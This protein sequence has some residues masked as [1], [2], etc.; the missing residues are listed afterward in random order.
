[1]K[2]NGRYFDTHVHLDL[3]DD[4]GD[5][6]Q[7]LHLAR[8]SGVGQ[9]LVPGVKRNRW[10]DL[11]RLCRSHQGLFAAPGLHPMAADQWNDEARREL[12]SLLCQPKVAAIGEIGL[13]ATLPSPALNQQE[14]AFTGQLR[15]AVEVGLPVLIYCRQAT[16]RLL[17]ILDR[18]HARRVGGIFHAFSGSEEVAREA[19]SLGFAIGVGGSVTYENARRLP[20]V[21]RHIDAEWLVLETDAPDM[22]PH[23]HRGEANK[24]AWLPL[25]AATVAKLRGYDMEQ[26]TRITTANARRILRLP[27]GE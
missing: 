20:E 23:P 19:I 25:I 18:E 5:L 7:E 12:E 3:L 17:E 16:G 1:M 8:Q 11:M 21:V 27:A 13:D 24:P 10:P 2:E 6:P 9:F 22:A 14:E 4:R 26:T 15:L